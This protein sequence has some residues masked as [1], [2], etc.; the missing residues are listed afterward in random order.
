MDID[1]DQ[2]QGLGAVWMVIPSFPRCSHQ[3]SDR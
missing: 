2:S 1:S 3:G